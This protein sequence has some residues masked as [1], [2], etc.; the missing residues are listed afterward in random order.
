LALNACIIKGRP[1]NLHL[2]VGYKLY[3]QHTH[4]PN[5][6]RDKSLI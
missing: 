3:V 1:L 4:R 6:D 2:H 5:V